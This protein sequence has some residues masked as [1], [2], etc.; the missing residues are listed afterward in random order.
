MTSTGDGKALLVSATA[1]SG[2]AAAH[3]IDEFL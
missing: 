1:F 3:L 2:F